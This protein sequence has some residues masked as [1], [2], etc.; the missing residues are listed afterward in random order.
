MKSS[1]FV[2]WLGLVSVSAT[3]APILYNINFTTTSGIAPT[4]GSFTYDS[5]IPAFT[6]FTVVWNG[7]TFD[8]TSSANT[9][10]LDG[11]CDTPAA[12]PGDLFRILSGECGTNEKAWY[13]IVGGGFATYTQIGDFTYPDLGY[14]NAY[15][16]TLPN[17]IQQGGQGTYTIS[18]VPE[19]ASIVSAVIGGI[20]L[21]WRVRRA[22]IRFAGSL[23]Q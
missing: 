11:A 12:D 4:T 6:S 18:A 7:L 5:A 16:P 2:V 19:P 21:A 23:R 3:A 10:F 14:A 9:P 22:P 8:L 15:L 20:L 17:A 1:L 13:A